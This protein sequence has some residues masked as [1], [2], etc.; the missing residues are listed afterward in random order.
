MHHW[1]DCHNTVENWARVTNTTVQCGDAVYNTR[2]SKFTVRG[3][4][5]YFIWVSSPDKPD[6]EHRMFTFFEEPPDLENPS[7]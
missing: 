3:F 2:G 7:I 5:P 1:D 6:N 4:G